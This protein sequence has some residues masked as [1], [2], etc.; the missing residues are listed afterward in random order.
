MKRLY[1]TIALVCLSSMVFAVTYPS[2]PYKNTSVYNLQAELEVPMQNLNRTSVRAVPSRSVSVR[3]VSQNSSFAL[4]MQASSNSTLHSYGSGSTVSGGNASVGHANV[5]SP[6]F[7]ASSIIL[8]KRTIAPDVQQLAYTTYDSPETMT[9]RAEKPSTEGD[10]PD[11][12]DL[13]IPV[14]N[15]MTT[16]LLLLI[17]YVL[18]IKRKRR[19]VTL[20]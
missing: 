1:F 12:P 8:S 4:T 6:T 16:L 15:G 2:K 13:W 10:D 5:S 14:G 9:L 11:N 7:S 17:A 19:A 20:R 3:A 18:I